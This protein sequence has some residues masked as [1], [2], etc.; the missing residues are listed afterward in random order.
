MLV[1]RQSTIAILINLVKNLTS[2]ICTTIV[3]ELNLCLID[4]TRVLTC[5]RTINKNTLK[6]KKTCKTVLS[7]K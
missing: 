7:S 6:I 3:K 5:Q 4:L 2:F 1:S